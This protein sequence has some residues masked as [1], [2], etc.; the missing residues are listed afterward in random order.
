[1][2]FSAVILAGGK[3]L[4]MGTDKAF[5]QLQG[6][7]LLERQIQLAREIGAKEVFI[8]GRPYTDYSPFDCDVLHDRFTEAGP[9]A[10]M[11]CA[12]A[13]INSEL[14]LVLAVD[15]PGLT[16]C[17]LTQLLAK[18]SDKGIIP[19]LNGRIEA[20]CAFYPKAAGRLCESLLVRHINQA[21]FFAK[22]CVRMRLAEFVEVNASDQSCF[23]NWNTP[24]DTCEQH[25]KSSTS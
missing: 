3:S 16:N 1:M 4:R 22:Q 6:Q 14:L 19:R 21:G 20:L 2:N 18:C 10:G 17:F 23:F 25:L 24:Q 5:L 11:E 9:L 7:L 12:L 15:M 13:T 8:S